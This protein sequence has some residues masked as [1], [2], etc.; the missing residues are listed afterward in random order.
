MPRDAFYRTLARTLPGPGR[1]LFNALPW[2]P[3]V[4]LALFVHRVDGLPPGLYLLIR[5]PESEAALRE[6]LAED[7]LWQR[8]E[9]CPD[10]LP[11][12]RLAKR[13]TRR[14][15]MQVSCFQEI[16]SDGCFSLGMIAEFEGSLSRYGPWFYP[17][18]FWECGMIG[19]VLY[20][21]VEAA[22]LRGTGIGCFFDD[23][24]HQVLGLEGMRFQDL[25][26]FTVGGPVEDARLTTLPPY[27]ARHRA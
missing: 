7:F 25:Y 6:S 3:C 4:H 19:Q 22:G 26:H 17:R 15:S 9:N 13:D 5:N 10:Q 12:Y 23:P 1:F 18:L 11:L 24:M 8:P 27:P 16:A 14:T 21:E 2:P 20:L